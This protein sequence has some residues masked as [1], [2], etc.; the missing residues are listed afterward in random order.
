MWLGKSSHQFGK[1]SQFR[2][3]SITTFIA[4]LLAMAKA[5]KGHNQCGHFGL[6]DVH[7]E[8]IVSLL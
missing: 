3:R 5:R 4:L 8:N 1:Y 7:S 6:I 2:E